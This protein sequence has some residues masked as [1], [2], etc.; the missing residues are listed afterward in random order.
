MPLVAP[1]VRA[2]DVG[3][4]YNK[5][6]AGGRAWESNPGP[7]MLWDHRFEPW[8]YKKDR[9]ARSGDRTLDLQKGSC[10]KVRGLNPGPAKTSS[11]QGT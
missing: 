2:S 9:V 5:P 10:Y 3:Q 4:G 6:E 8:T 11:V 7:T 1:F